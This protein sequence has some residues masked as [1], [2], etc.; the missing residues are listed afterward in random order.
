[1]IVRIEFHK[2]YDQNLIMAFYNKP[3][4][5]CLDSS[6]A[7]DITPPQVKIQHTMYLTFW[8]I[9]DAKLIKFYG[10][11]VAINALTIVPGVKKVDV[12]LEYKNLQD[13]ILLDK[14]LTMNS[15]DVF[16]LLESYI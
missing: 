6:A 13:R 1:M 3:S 8:N 5:T 11:R 14:V 9:D 12:L 2:M 10:G 7:I 16:N 15:D 4:G